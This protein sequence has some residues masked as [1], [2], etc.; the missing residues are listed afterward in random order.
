M[1]NTIQPPKRQTFRNIHS[2]NAV[3]FVLSNSAKNFSITIDAVNK[4]LTT[5]VLIIRQRGLPLTYIDVYNLLNATSISPI[6]LRHFEILPDM[7]GWWFISSCRCFVLVQRYRS[8]LSSLDS[9]CPHLLVTNIIIGS[10]FAHIILGYSSSG[11]NANV[12]QPKGASFNLNQGYLEVNKCD[13]NA[14]SPH[15][16]AI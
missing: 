5:K 8:T 2:G 15:L 12:L 16:E 3:F 11:C 14:N 4:D 9:K 1:Q 13:N 6:N 10:S 7:M